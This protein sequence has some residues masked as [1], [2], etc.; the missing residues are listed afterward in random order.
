[1]FT[2]IHLLDFNYLGSVF[3]RKQKK[4]FQIISGHRC[5]NDSSNCWVQFPHFVKWNASFFFL[6]CSII[7]WN[8]NSVTEFCDPSFFLLI[9]LLVLRQHWIGA[10]RT[11]KSDVSTTMRMKHECHVVWDL[12]QA[13]KSILEICWG[14]TITV[15]LFQFQMIILWLVIYLILICL[16]RNPLFHWASVDFNH[17]NFGESWL[18][19]LQP[20]IDWRWNLISWRRVHGGA[21]MQKLGTLLGL[22]RF[23]NV[24][25]EVVRFFANAR[26]DE[27][28]V[29]A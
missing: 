1:M 7:I 21:I 25:N 6:Q 9:S 29:K 8:W 2:T 22:T 3:F 13:A 4:I 28:M 10:S 23:P 17:V 11:L 12:E 19:W 15:T 16:F 20:P 14:H 18:I 5:Q 26:D 24:Q 27:L